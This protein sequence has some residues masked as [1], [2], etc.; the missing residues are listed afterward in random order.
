MENTAERVGLCKYLYSF[1]LDQN[2]SLENIADK[3]DKPPELVKNIFAGTISP[4]V[5]DL[6]LI[7]NQ[8]GLK[9]TFHQSVPFA[10]KKIQ[11]KSF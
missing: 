10:Q 6:I 2:I 8:L 5:D 4:T 7:A 11:N 1:A 9:L 3:I